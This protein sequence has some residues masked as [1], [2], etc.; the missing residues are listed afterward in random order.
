MPALPA[1]GNGGPRKG[2]GMVV[3]SAF[4][5]L[6]VALALCVASVTISSPAFARSHHGV[7]RYHHA[8]YAFHHVRRHYAVSPTRHYA[9]HRYRHTIRVARVPHELAVQRL[10]RFADAHA[11]VAPDTSAAPMSGSSSSLVME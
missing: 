4:R 6:L 2:S 8:R 10:R 3:F 7:S 11:S 1:G 9:L 5:R